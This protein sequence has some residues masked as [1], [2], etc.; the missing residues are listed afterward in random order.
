MAL[1]S[2]DALPVCQAYVRE[3]RGVPFVLQGRD[4][5]H[6]LDCVG[7]IFG[8]LLAGGWQPEDPGFLHRR[9]YRLGDVAR[10]ALGELEREWRCIW[11]SDAED[12]KPDSPVFAGFD[13]AKGLVRPGDILAC[14]DFSG[15]SGIR[16]LLWVM[17]VMG[18]AS[19]GLDILVSHADTR[20]GEVVQHHLDSVWNPQVCAVFRPFDREVEV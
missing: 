5:R 20:Q 10:D 9:S 6:G 14:R 12:Q 8:A 18:S 7:L 17:T 2:L 4:P 3:A 19:G 13:L 16:H 1:L 15:R 11:I